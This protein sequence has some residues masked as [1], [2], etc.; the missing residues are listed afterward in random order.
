MCV[1]CIGVDY[2]TKKLAKKNQFLLAYAA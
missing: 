1:F 2:D